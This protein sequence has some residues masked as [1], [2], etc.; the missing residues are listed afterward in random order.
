MDSAPVKA[1]ASMESLAL[2]QAALPVGDHLLVTGVENQE[3]KVEAN[4]NPS[5]AQFITAPDHQMKRLERRWQRLNERPQGPSD[6][7]MKKRSC[8]AIRRTTP[9]MTPMPASP[10]SLARP[11]NSTTTAAWPWTRPEVSSPTSARTS[12]TAGT[13]STCLPLSGRCKAG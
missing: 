5:S 11:G 3:K 13:A 1:N 6:Q 8:L 12:P 2:K 9:R 7:P 4:A 10:S